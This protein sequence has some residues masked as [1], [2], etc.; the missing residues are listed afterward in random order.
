MN[1]LCFNLAKF[2]TFITFNGDILNKMGLTPTWFAECAL[3]T[4]NGINVIPTMP[5]VQDFLNKR[6]DLYRIVHDRYDDYYF[7]TYGIPPSTRDIQLMYENVLKGIFALLVDIQSSY[8][9]NYPPRSLLNI[10]LKGQHGEVV[11]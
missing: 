4:H 9:R 1:T 3:L 7:D 10:S 6:V 11:I 5:V 8:L 2:Q